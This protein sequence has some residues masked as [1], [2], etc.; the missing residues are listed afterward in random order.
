MTHPNFILDPQIAD[1]LATIN[2]MV[3]GTAPSLASGTQ[4]CSLAHSLALAGYNAVFAQ[5]QAYIVAQTAAA[6]DVIELLPSS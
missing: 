1:A 4:S 3:V 6:A 5:Q 2:S